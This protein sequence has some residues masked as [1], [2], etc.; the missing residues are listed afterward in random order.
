M[1]GRRVVDWSGRESESGWERSG[2]IGMLNKERR[3]GE[4][5]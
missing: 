3:E 5:E 4:D 2:E 1:D